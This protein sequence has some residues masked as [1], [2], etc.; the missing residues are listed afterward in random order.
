MSSDFSSMIDFSEVDNPDPFDQPT[1][2]DKDDS[3]LGS[4]TQTVNGDCRDTDP[5]HR[6][7]Q[8]H[9]L[10]L[11]SRLEVF[12]T[13]IVDGHRLKQEKLYSMIQDL[14]RRSLIPFELFASMEKIRDLENRAAHRPDALP[15]ISEVEDIVRT[16]LEL[17]DAYVINS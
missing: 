4:L 10:E 5:E 17:E 13:G 16:Y 2:E 3:R 1:Q 9:S 7:M 8:K 12:V 15:E 6:N 11:R 14:R